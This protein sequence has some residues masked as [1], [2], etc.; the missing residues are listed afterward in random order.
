[1]KL[2]TKNVNRYLK[3]K[4]RDK[5]ATRELEIATWELKLATFSC[6]SLAI[7]TFFLPYKN[8]DFIASAIA[9][10]QGEGEIRTPNRFF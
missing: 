5:I 2:N 8:R 7:A 10:G 3:T 4:I 6:E 9:E 1:M